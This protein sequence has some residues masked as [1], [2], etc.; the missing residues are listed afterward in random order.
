MGVVE[1]KRIKNEACSRG[2]VERY[3]G[4]RLRRAPGST[5]RPRSSSCPRPAG[6]V[7]ALTPSTN[8]I[9][10]VYFKVLLALM[11]RNAVVVSPHP[12]AREVSADAVRTLAA[13]RRRGGRAGRLPAGGRGAHHPADR[14]ADGRSHHRRDRRHRRHRRGAR[15][16]PLGQP[17]DRASA[18]ATCRR[19]STHR[20]PRPPPPSAWSSPRRS[21][22]RSCAPTSRARSSR[23]GSPMGFVRGAEQRTAATCSA[24]SDVPRVR[25]TCYP[26]GRIAVELIGKDAGRSPQRP[27]SASRRSTRVLVAPFSLVVP[28]EPLAREKLFPLLGLVRVPD[29]R[30]GIE[31]RPRDAADR[32]RRPLGRD[33]LA[34]SRA[35]CMAYGAAVQGAARGRERAAGA[36][37]RP[38]STPTSRRR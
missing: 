36:P 29:A 1:H 11:T 16:L 8:P 21:T 12:L 14:G 18:P 2:L 38:A 35:R 5:P 27:G 22:T 31:R 6:V 25:A 26:E 3:G 33:P 4:A 30:R 19:W 37:A 20:R 15:R 13:G 32:R 34:R 28:E 24:R 9:A 17:G 7:L 10:T 23:S